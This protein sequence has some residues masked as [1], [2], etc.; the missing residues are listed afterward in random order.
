MLYD[1]LKELVKDIWGDRQ[2]DVHQWKRLPKRMEYHLESNFT[3]H[4]MECTTFP[5]AKE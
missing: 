4:C 2:K 1:T 5:S 3:R